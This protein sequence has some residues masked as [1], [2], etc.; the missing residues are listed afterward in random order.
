METAIAASLL[1]ALQIPNTQQDLLPSS[2]KAPD[3]M[4]PQL[5]VTSSDKLPSAEIIYI[6]AAEKII[7]ENLL[8]ASEKPP[9]APQMIEESQ[10]TISASLTIPAQPTLK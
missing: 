1:D 7:T 4:R 3:P 8:S 9:R 5:T 6:S 2:A 10:K